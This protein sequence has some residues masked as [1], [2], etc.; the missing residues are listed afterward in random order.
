MVSTGCQLNAAAWL[1]RAARQ[2]TSKLKHTPRG[3]RVCLRWQARGS[4]A[5]AN[6]RPRPGP[7][8]LHLSWP[9]PGASFPA[10]EGV[11]SVGECHAELGRS[12]LGFLYFWRRTRSGART[13]NIT[14]RMTSH[15]AT[16]SSARRSAEQDARLLAYL[17]PSWTAS[18]SRN[19][20]TWSI[21][22]IHMH[23]CL[24]CAHSAAPVRRL[25]TSCH[26][27]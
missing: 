11:G 19:G 8:G 5:R 9:R 12:R 7:R 1:G 13:R 17:R 23:C 25:A 18:C 6:L 24:C 3:S 27:V 14:S 16:S 4:R 20:T 2:G 26:V 10:C 21:T 15:R 22:S